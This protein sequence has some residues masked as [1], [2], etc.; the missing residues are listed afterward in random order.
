MKQHLCTILLLFV[1]CAQQ[2]PIHPN[3]EVQLAHNVQQIPSQLEGNPHS[4]TL[5]HTKQIQPR[6]MELNAHVQD[7][8]TLKQTYL[9]KWEIASHVRSNLV[10]QTPL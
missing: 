10:T 4:V 6:A 9:E 8:P 5:V 3:L 7:T 1:L 2:A